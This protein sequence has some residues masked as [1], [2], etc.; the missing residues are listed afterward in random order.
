[1]ARADKKMSRGDAGPKGHQH[2]GDENPDEAFDQDDI[3]SEIK[4]R[5]SLQGVD[6]GQFRGER[7]AEADAKRKTEGVVE[8]FR[9]LD[10]KTRAPGRG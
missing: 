4:G 6:Q 2:V 9:R 10:P 1:M 7:H 5:S 3:A 8:S